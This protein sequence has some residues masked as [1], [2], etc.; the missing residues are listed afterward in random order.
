MDKKILTN[1]EKKKIVLDIL[2]E[3]SLSGDADAGIAWLNNCDDRENKKKE[4]C[5]VLLDACLNKNNFGACL[6]W[7]E[8]C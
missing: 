8:H 6:V 5:D 2:L 3:K 7:I 1:E 4:V